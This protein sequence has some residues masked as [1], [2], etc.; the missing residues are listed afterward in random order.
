MRLVY[1]VLISLSRLLFG[2]LGLRIRVVGDERVPVVGP[3]VL[4]C[5]HVS[6][7]DFVFAGLA[8]RRSRRLVRFLCRS[9]VWGRRPF[10][11][12]MRSMQ[13]VPV[14]RDHGASAYLLARSA[15]RRGEVV[16]IFPEGGVSRSYVLRPVLR[17]A[18]RLAMDTGAPLL[19]VV[20]WG[21]QR[22]WLVD[23]RPRPRRGVAVSV[24][25]GP[26]LAIDPD[27]DVTEQ[28]SRLRACLQELLARAQVEHPDQ[29]RPGEPA[30]WHP[31][32][33]GGDA[34]TPAV[35]AAR[36]NRPRRTVP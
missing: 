29:P 32:H 24:L 13:H 7:L 18:V 31:A 16:G 33:L 26:P 30:P 25:V 21:P 6:Y 5:N 34:P 3:A 36:E 10:G 4:A 22:L 35:A 17:G 23:H 2:L 1:P 19:P 14:V 9:D 20:V 11:W 28:T 15:L 27:G 12:L 8:A